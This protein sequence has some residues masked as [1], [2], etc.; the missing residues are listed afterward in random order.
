M[1]KN[2]IEILT[3]YHEDHSDLIY[4][5]KSE[6]LKTSYYSFF[7]TRKKIFLNKL[8]LIIREFICVFKGLIHLP[9]QHNKIIYCLTSNFSMLFLT[10]IFS[11]LLGKKFH[12]YIYNFYL[13]AAE[14]N[15]FMR[16]FLKFLL[17]CKNT[18]MIVQSPREVLF[19]KQFSHN[20][21]YFVPYCWKFDRMTENKT[22]IGGHSDYI[23][24]GGYTNRDYSLVIECAKSKPEW[25]F[26]IVI[27]SLNKE[28]NDFDIPSN[29]V[30]HKNL[31]EF[32][33]NN[34]LKDAEIVLIPLKLDVGSSGQ[35]LCL[36]AM[37][38]A[39]PIVYCD[40]SAIN[41]YFTEETG[42]P[43]KINDLD[44]LTTGIYKFK[45]N[46]VWRRK[47]GSQAYV[48]LKNHFT[49]KQKNEKICQLIINNIPKN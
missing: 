18:T 27:S 20:E 1:V 40:V 14:N 37:S 3:M 5:L 21:V 11:P 10:K 35:M 33:F 44:S 31:S 8:E 24:T 6:G 28:F 38:Y 15:K 41:Y 13:H 32:S 36:A 12:L 47:I 7:S 22:S 34:L 9:K 4:I 29:V 43:Y 48:R 30:L 17:S 45:E 26:V 49:E 42:I 19:Y 23:F 16:L 2:N 25:N 46:H 39:C